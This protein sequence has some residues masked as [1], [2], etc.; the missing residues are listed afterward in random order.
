MVVKEV[1]VSLVAEGVRDKRLLLAQCDGNDYIC[2]RY[3]DVAE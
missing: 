3:S 1:G 2:K